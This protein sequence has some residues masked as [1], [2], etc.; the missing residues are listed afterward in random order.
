MGFVAALLYALLINGLPLVEVIING[1][2]PG[3]LLLLYWFETVLLVITGAIRIVLHRRATAK[4]GHYVAAH[5]ASHR[6]AIAPKVRREMSDENAYLHGFLVVT[7]IFTIA[8]G[9]FV[10]LL[11][12][13]FKIAGPV[14]WS[15]T[16][17]ALAYVV[18]V[19]AIFLLWD[20]PRL[21]GWTFAQL[22]QHVGQA[23]LRVIVTQL[24]LIF[25]F[26]VMGIAGTPWGLVGTFVAFRSLSDASMAW[27]GGFT[28][29]RDLPPGL[30]RVLS[31]TSKQSV[32]TLEAEFDAM[33]RDGEEIAALLEQ[34]IGEVRSDLRPEG[35]TG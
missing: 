28:K 17:I 26:P 20:L 32:D 31:R 16:R 23:P 3:V 6:D 34:P 4:A 19:Q 27:L 33:K 29:R 10:L 8:H 9:I 13:L 11:V 22:G 18:A 25:G 7:G 5:I 24:G 15:D 30:A 12:F 35:Q 14:S 2:S 21:R 1:R